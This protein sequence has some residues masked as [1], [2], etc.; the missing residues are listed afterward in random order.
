MFYFANPLFLIALAGILVP[1]IIHLVRLRRYNK[2]Y[3]SN[4]DM[5]SSIEAEQR[6]RS[7]L[8]EWLILAARILAITS[9]VLAFAQPRLCNKS[10]ASASGGSCVSVYID[11]SFS[12]GG[13]GACGILLEEAK[14]KARE[15]ARAYPSDTRFQLLT[16]DNLGQSRRSLVR[17]EFL[18]A[19]DEVGLSSRTLPVSVAMERQANFGMIASSSRTHAYV[20]SDFQRSTCDWTSVE[21][22]VDE[23]RLDEADG[24]RMPD[25][26]TADS[27]RPLGS[28]WV[29]V[30]VAPVKQANVY[31]DTLWL[32]APPATA[33]S[34]VS[35]TLAIRNEGDSPIEAL[36]VRLYTGGEQKAL[37]T[38]DIS[39][40]GSA[41]VKLGFSLR[42]TGA[43]NGYVELSDYPVTF[44]DKLYFSINVKP[45]MRVL[46]LYGD[47]PD[48]HL[49]RLFG[50]DSLV[51]YSD[52]PPAKA[53]LSQ[54]DDMDFISLTSL[55]SIPSGLSQ[56]LVEYVRKGG[57][58]LLAPPADCDIASYNLL[59]A[60]VGAPQLDNFVECHQTCSSINYDAPLYKNV[61]RRQADNI[62]LPTVDGR[63]QTHTPAGGTAEAIISMADGAPWLTA[64]GCGK[65]T[66]Y[67]LVTP[68]ESVH[69]NF[70]QLPLFVPTIYNMALYS[71]RPA[72]LYYTIGK[73]EQIDLG[74]VSGDATATVT[75]DA[76]TEAS[77]VTLRHEGRRSFVVAD[78]ME[79]EAG[80]YRVSDG[81]SELGV[82]LN[83]DRSES[84]MEFFD[85]GEIEAAVKAMQLGNIELVKS[86]SHPLD[87]VIR[88]RSGGSS[89]SPWFLLAAVAFLICEALLIASRPQEPQT[90][91]TILT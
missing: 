76:S 3:F 61:F 70:A 29:L 89:L 25:D 28:H 40:H 75:K 77:L 67:L 86:G 87:E 21:Q 36:P 7:R 81:S 41:E 23:Y 1:V 42:E 53:D 91:Q 63:F 73:G 51:S 15:I 48:D 37:A 80:N 12:M 38:V 54:A 79:S 18:A 43:L 17:E 44:D 22:V 11:N 78:D 65:G 14:S 24:K 9:L 84:L 30:P 33:G 4:T 39:K 26:P 47:R 46:A 13:E 2:V 19:I 49:R 34:G 62:E 50:H 68:L 60:A 59:L 88:Q 5:L 32:D 35:L 90:G 6:S 56:A 31:I 82:S 83:H 8:R 55:S 71:R 58:L 45:V 27:M 74:D 69:G 52:S 20:I 16:N 72:Q 10:Q 85:S 57:T 64:S 66:V